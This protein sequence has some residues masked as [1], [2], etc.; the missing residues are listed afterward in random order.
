MQS[1]KFPPRTIAPQRLQTRTYLLPLELS[2]S[3]WKGE[4]GFEQSIGGMQVNF[5]EAWNR[6]NTVTDVALSRWT[7]ARPGYKT[8]KLQRQGVGERTVYQITIE[9]TGR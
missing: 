5:D 4:L 1:F 8:F 7:A 3:T 9:E 6:L 2:G